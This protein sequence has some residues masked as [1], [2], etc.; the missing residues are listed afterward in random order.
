MACS[1]NLGPSLMDCLGV[2][3]EF[4]GIQRGEL[5]FGMDCKCCSVNRL[6]PNNDIAVFVDEDQVRDADLREVLR[7]W[8][9]PEMVSENGISD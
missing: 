2:S 6:V 8:I 4:L 1:V 9:E 3:R 7:E 5:T